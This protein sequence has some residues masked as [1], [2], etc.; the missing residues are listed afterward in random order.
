MTS[1][2]M[3]LAVEHS[4]T[5]ADRLAQLD[6]AELGAIDLAIAD[7]EY[8]V[9]M[10]ALGCHL[11]RTETLRRHAGDRMDARRVAHAVQ[12]F[13]ECFVRQILQATS[14][15]SASPLP[16]AAD[17]PAGGGAKDVTAIPTGRGR[18]PQ[19]ATDEPA[20]P[21]LTLVPPAPTCGFVPDRLDHMAC[22]DEPG[23]AGMHHVRAV[24]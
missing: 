18:E 7:R 2:N 21:R 23:H 14:G 10:A 24:R 1:L 12:A 6:R 13:S 15:P 8:D 3:E 20:A 16:P 11:E 19:G 5:V 17:F 4:D 9:A 22:F